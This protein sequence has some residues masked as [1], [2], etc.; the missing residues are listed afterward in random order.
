MTEEHFNALPTGYKLY[1]YTIKSVLGH[2]GFGITYLAY[3]ENLN[4]DVAIKEYLP[5]EFAVR[6][7]AETVRPR[8]SADSDDYEWGLERFMKE[9]QTLALFRHPSIVPVFRF[10]KANGTAYMVMEYQEGESLAALMRKH[11]GEFTEEDLLQLVEPILNGLAEV[12]KAGYLHRDVKPGNIYIR[13]DGTPVLLDFGAARAAV[14]RKSQSLTSIVTPGYA[15][16]EQYFADG[17]QGPW[18]DIYALAAIL[19]QA[20]AGRIPPEAPARVKNDPISSAREV[21]KGRFSPLFLAAIDRALMVEEEDRPQ[22]TTEWR[23]MLIG[24]TPAFADDGAVPAVDQSATMFAGAVP[25]S[26]QQTGVATQPGPTSGPTAGPTSGPTG[27]AGQQGPFDGRQPVTGPPPRQ[28]SGSAVRVAVIAVAVLFL[29]TVG[30]GAGYFVLKESGGLKDFL[31]TDNSTSTG[32]KQV[33]TEDPD[34]ARRKAEAEAKRK[35]EAE[36]K[37]KAE[38]EAKRK[39]EAEAEAKRKADADAA[40]KRKAEEAR[41]KAEADAKRRAEAE[42]LKREADAKRK[43][44]AEAQRKADEE[45]R[46]AEAERLKREEAQREADRRKREEEARQRA[47]EERKRREEEERKRTE[48]ANLNNG[49]ISCPDSLPA[50]NGKYGHAT[51]CF[52]VRRVFI[53]ALSTGIKGSTSRWRNSRSG[54]SGT[55]TVLRA[56]QR[57]DGTFCRQ[58]QQTLTTHGVTRRGVGM[59]C[60]LGNQWKIAG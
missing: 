56:V 44:E 6:Q 33:K 2:G 4:K 46:K 9:A 41:R 42:R 54:N 21:G 36:A 58:F 8:S 60:F 10:F 47:E 26:A 3:D 7:G 16:L 19:Y 49:G 23:D 50:L 48:T 12:H 20:V 1:E 38:A 18:T 51:D 32:T 22:S 40:A 29:M 55:L 34:L 27:L 11:R 53:S 5:A 13:Q 52:F 15:P 14:G 39:A 30:A 35:A 59:A 37:R 17:N 45:K 24:R 28:K 31:S 57:P 25:P 43:A